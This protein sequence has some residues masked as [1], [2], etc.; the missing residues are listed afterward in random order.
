MKILL[1]I[2]ILI[3]LSMVVYSAESNRAALRRDYNIQLHALRDAIVKALKVLESKAICGIKIQTTTSL[4]ELE[5]KPLAD[6]KSKLTD[7]TN[8]IDIGLSALDPPYPTIR[9]PGGLRHMLEISEDYPVTSDDIKEIERIVHQL[10]ILFPS[11]TATPVT[12]SLFPIRGFLFGAVAGFIAGILSMT[13]CILPSNKRAME[14]AHSITKT[15]PKTS[16]KW[17]PVSK[18]YQG[19]KKSYKHIKP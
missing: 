19:S 18:S 11:S 14:A 8:T 15:S 6:F 17:T 1:F 10:D 3:S 13:G 2:S 12:S 16:N 9:Y 7:A 4:A 5:N